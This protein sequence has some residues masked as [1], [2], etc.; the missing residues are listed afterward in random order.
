MRAKVTI[1]EQRIGGFTISHLTSDAESWRWQSYL[2]SKN[3][4]PGETCTVLTHDS[5]PM[6]MMQDSHAEYKE[7]LWLWKKAQGKV[8]I[9]GLGIG[10]VNEVLISDTSITKVTILEKNQEVIDMVWPY[11]AKDERF[12]LIHADIHTWTPPEGS[13]WNVAWFDTYHAGDEGT[14]FEYRDEMLER[15]GSMV[16]EVGFWGLT[17]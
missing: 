13:H 3:E 5:Y 16:D 17:W 11:C 10:M 4:P 8:L 15:Y 2:R 9:G 6:P 12:E 1:P 14:H 7:H